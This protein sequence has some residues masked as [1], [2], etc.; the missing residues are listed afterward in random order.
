[1][2][3]KGGFDMVFIQFYNGGYC[4]ARSRVNKN[5]VNN[6]NYA[7]WYTYLKKSG[8][9]STNARI[10]IGLLGGPTG[11]VN[12]PGDFLNVAEVKNLISVYGRNAQI[13]GV[14][15]WDG[16]AAERYRG[17]DL[18]GASQRYWDVVKTAMLVSFVDVCRYHVYANVYI[19]LPIQQEA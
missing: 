17:S 11:S 3:Q 13:G 18:V 2:I 9:K 8:S 1:M 19:E 10:Y 14:M 12:H 7:A 16:T 5:P 15:L 6:F 4:T